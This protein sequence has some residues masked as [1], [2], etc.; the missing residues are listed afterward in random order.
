MNWNSL[1]RVH[2][3]QIELESGIVDFFLRRGEVPEYPKKNLSE[4][5]R[6]PNNKLNPDM[7]CT[8]QQDS[9]RA[10]LVGG[11]CCHHR[12]TFAPHERHL[13]VTT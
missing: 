9:N 12:V 2:A 10:T 3:F 5:G 11:E 13:I 8:V 6:E 7:A 4:E 1:K